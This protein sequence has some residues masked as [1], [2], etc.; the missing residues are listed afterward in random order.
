MEQI[1]CPECSSY[2]VEKTKSGLGIGIFFIIVGLFMF[3]L[4]GL[5]V[6]PSGKFMFFTG[7]VIF[8][9][10]LFLLGILGVFGSIQSIRSKNKEY[11]CSACKYKW[12]MVE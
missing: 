1:Q 10:L 4:K 3:F 2:D 5:M 6:L 9:S 8:S 7:W 12:N 11:I